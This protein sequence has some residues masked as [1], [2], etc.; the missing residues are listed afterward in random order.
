MISLCLF[1]TTMV[2]THIIL[3]FSFFLYLIIIITNATFLRCLLYI[4]YI[5][6]LLKNREKKE[7]DRSDRILDTMKK[8]YCIA[9]RMSKNGMTYNLS[10]KKERKNDHTEMVEKM[11]E[12][13][14][15]KY[16]KR[17]EG[18]PVKKKWFVKKKHNFLA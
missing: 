15:F 2:T 16:Q 8:A 11:V 5:F 18:P 3:L 1:L 9:F 10:K 6:F 4:Y 7:D 12:Q 14:I 13:C 17:H